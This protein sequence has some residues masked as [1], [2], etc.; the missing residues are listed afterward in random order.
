MN[1]GVSTETASAL[2]SSASRVSWI[3]SRVVMAPV[4]AYTGTRPFTW[5]TVIWKRSRFS[6]GESP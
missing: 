5:S 1:I 4:P 6:S 2:A 3:A